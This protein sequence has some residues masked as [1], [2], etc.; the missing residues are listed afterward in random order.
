M[1]HLTLENLERFFSL[2]VVAAILFG[3]VA[4][5]LGWKKGA[6]IADELSEGFADARAHIQGAVDAPGMLEK[7]AL[8]CK[9]AAVIAA[10]TSG[11][12]A[13]DV[14]PMVRDLVAGVMEGKSVTAKGLTLSLDPT[15]GHVQIDP[16]GLAAKSAHKISKWAKKIF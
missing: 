12:K 3:V 13:V 2:A 1:E 4:R 10:G 14:R 11:V 16:T 7:Q 15:T 9:A 8:I 6:L 5:A